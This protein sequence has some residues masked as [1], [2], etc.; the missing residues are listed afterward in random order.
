[1]TLLHLSHVSKH[2]GSLHVIEDLSLSVDENSVYG[3]LGKNGAGKTTVMKMILGFLPLSGG[4]IRVCN[5]PVRYG[6]TGTN[7]LMGYLP[8][9][10]EFYGFMNPSE[11][12]LLCG[13]ISGMKEDILK[14]SSERLLALVG[15]DGIKRRIGS[16]SRGMKQR[17]G[18]AQ[19]LLHSPKLL[20]CDE[21]TSALDPVGRKEILDILSV[22]SKETTIVFST[23]I[24]ADVERVCDRVGILEGGRLVLDGGLS[25]LRAQGGSDT[26]FL[27]PL[28]KEQLP[29][30][31]EVVKRT[32]G[33]AKIKETDTGVSFILTDAKTG[34]PRLFTLLGSHSVP[35]RRYVIEE[36]TLENIFIHAVTQKA[37]K[38]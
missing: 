36:P 30:L 34:C 38:E 17:L 25:Q 24:L 23:H 20:L 16:F 37:E 10:P 3:F 1:M 31:I 35:L 18:I 2:F 32:P 29:E 22:A 7:R 21:P 15:L 11:Y 33:I 5:Q 4:E 19:A 28:V 27:E 6:H 12:L 26:V 8:D 14:A 9:V 13:K